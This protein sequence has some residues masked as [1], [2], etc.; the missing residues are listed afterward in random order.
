MCC[1][2]LR[3]KAAGR[4]TGRELVGVR[5]EHTLDQGRSGTYGETLKRLYYEDQKELNNEIVRQVKAGRPIDAVIQDLESIVSNQETVQAIV[6]AA[7]E[8]ELTKQAMRAQR[9]MIRKLI[10]E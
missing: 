1:A 7:I 4:H 9:E 10:E 8:I 6:R 2:I 3:A 5:P